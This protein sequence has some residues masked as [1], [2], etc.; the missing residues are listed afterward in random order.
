MTSKENGITIGLDKSNKNELK[1]EFYSVYAIEDIRRCFIMKNEFKTIMNFCDKNNIEVCTLSIN[2][3]EKVDLNNKEEVDKAL[4]L[5]EGNMSDNLPFDR[6]IMYAVRQSLGL[7]K[8]DTSK[9]DIIAT[10]DKDKILDNVCTWN[11]LIN[12]G[13]IIKNWVENIY[14]V[15][16][17]S[18]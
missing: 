8:Y 9:D 17:K 7:E 12:Y 6:D 4:K 18:E 1:C 16:L 15:E 14:G 5:I 13:Y 10:M 3:L 11:G 2:I